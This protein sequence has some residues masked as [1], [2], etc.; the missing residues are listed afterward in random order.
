MIIPTVTKNI[1]NVKS[2]TTRIIQGVLEK[3]KLLNVMF[4]AQ[5]EED[6][7]EC[8]TLQL[9]QFWILKTNSHPN[10]YATCMNLYTNFRNLDGNSV[11]TLQN[12]RDVTSALHYG[13][14]DKNEIP[15]S[16]SFL[17]NLCDRIFFPNSIWKLGVSSLI[18]RHNRPPFF[19]I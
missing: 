19:G 11:P 17:M 1:L 16:H 13:I 18:K 2:Q 3:L 12:V 14:R 6:K 7:C 8:A 10:S 4:A 15:K 9:P 5:R